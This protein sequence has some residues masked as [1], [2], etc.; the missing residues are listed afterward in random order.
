V[1]IFRTTY[2]CG[3]CD[4]LLV[5]APCGIESAPL[6]FNPHT[7]LYAYDDANVGV[8]KINTGERGQALSWVLGKGER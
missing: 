7:Q 6:I 5:V 4:L 2:S 3:T 8:P 1:K